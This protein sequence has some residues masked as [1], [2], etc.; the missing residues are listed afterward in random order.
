MTN[1]YGKLTI[2]QKEDKVIKGLINRTENNSYYLYRPI[3]ERVINIDDNYAFTVIILYNDMLHEI[4]TKI[5]LHYGDKDLINNTYY[6]E[7]KEEYI[8][9]NK[10]CDI[11]FK[12]S[13]EIE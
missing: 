9:E 13:V 11:Y 12:V 2:N 6:N 10:Q 8:L 3:I 4:E 1:L 5:I 7:L